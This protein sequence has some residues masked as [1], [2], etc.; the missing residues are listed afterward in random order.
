MRVETTMLRRTAA[1]VAVIV[2][3]VSMAKSAA[4]G[5]IAI[6]EWMYSPLASGSPAEFIE[7][8]NVSN[9]AVDMTNW[10]EDDSTRSPGKHSFGNLGIVQP[11][12]S[13]IACEGSNASGFRT[14]W[15]L[16]S[17]VKVITYGTTDG[18]GRA[19][20]INLYDNLGVLQDRL[21]YDDQTGK[22]PRTQGVSGN[23]PLAALFANNASAAVLS[24]ANDT[25]LSHR[26]GGSSTGDLG[27]PGVYTPYTVPEPSSIV[28]ALIALVG[29][30][31][32]RRRS[33]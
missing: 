30:I 11:G 7:F 21:T 18:L 2:I 9:A 25:Y 32:M 22:G 14:Y 20:E 1:I 13:V 17:S 8:T 23:L 19:D 3:V 15:G 12:E 31:G 6:T 27:N 33:L 16:A 4:A 10:S 5:S 26:D 28:L 24:A 29:L